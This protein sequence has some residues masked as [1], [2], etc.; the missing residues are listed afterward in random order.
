VYVL[1]SDY[2]LKDRFSFL[3]EDHDSYAF[4]SILRYIGVH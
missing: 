2:W 1:P 4:Q 3:F